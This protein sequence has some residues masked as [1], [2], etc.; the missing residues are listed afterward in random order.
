MAV[1]TVEQP[2]HGW[3]PA[4]PL[5]AGPLVAFGLIVVVGLW[6]LQFQAPQPP[7]PL[8]WPAA[9]VALALT[10][11]CGWPTAIGVA[12]GTAWLHAALGTGVPVSILLGGLTG[13]AGIASAV[14]LRHLRFDA[15]LARVRD[16]LLLLAVGGGLTAVL[17][18]I[19][20]TLLVAG[21][22]P[23]FPHT[24]GLCWI[25]DAMGLVLLAPPLLAARVPR[26]PARREL[27]AAG[28]VLLGAAWVW[29]VYAGGLSAPVALAL[30]Y[31]VFPLVLAV[32]L[33]FGAAV[34][35]VAVAAIAAT[36][37]ACTGLDKGPFSQA[38]MMANVLSLHAHLAM[39]GL[40][41]LMLA[42]ARTERDAADERARQHLRTLARAG[43][44][45][46]MSSMAAGIAHEINQPLSAVNSYAHAAQRMLRDGN[47]GD[48]LGDA[49]ERVVRGNERAAAI[50]RR[51]R[52]FLR[53]GDGERER[54]DLNELACEAIELSVP[55]YRR[56]RI[57]LTSQRAER[58]LPVEVDPVAIRQVVV[59]LLQ[60]ALEAVRESPTAGGRGWVRVTTRPSADGQWAELVV[61][62]SGPGLPDAERH[63]LFEPLVTHREGGTGLGLAIVRSLVEA[64]EGT[65]EAGDAE[66]GGAAFRVRLPAAARQRA[67]A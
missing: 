55:E 38:G 7:V 31:A 4:M 41:G 34:T 43:R 26:E 10:Y 21:L 15:R 6:A 25:A 30:S 53:T 61:E 49:L 65:V 22:T 13:G 14:V 35:G 52:T 45:D 51:V 63:Q 66:G 20:G 54:A 50:V 37:L 32:A 19:G 17:S 11:R 23:E 57:G 3:H 58:H 42:S 60:N 5:V 27:E 12:A 8:I 18:A 46:A 47:C 40:T 59:N 64:H 16:A 44:L 67:A 28:W 33:R 2:G 9:G 48:Q 62:D 36:A 39:L 29:E 1:T 24:F 56:Q